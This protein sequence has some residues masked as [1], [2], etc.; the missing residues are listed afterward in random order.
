VLSGRLRI[1]WPRGNQPPHLPSGLSFR[2]HDLGIDIGKLCPLPAMAGTS[3]VLDAAAA[4]LLIAALRKQLHDLDKWLLGFRDPVS[5]ASV[6]IEKFPFAAWSVR[7]LADRVGMDQ[8]SLK[9]DFVAQTGKTPMHALAEERMKYA[10]Q[11]LRDTNLK[12]GEVGERIGYHSQS[13]FVREFTKH[14]RVTPSRLR[15]EATCRIQ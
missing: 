12:I 4:L 8:S 7:A 5:R 3:A 9:T 2:T 1:D 15:K 6:L 10:I 11:F 13:A 14:F